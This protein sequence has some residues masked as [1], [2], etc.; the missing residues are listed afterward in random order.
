MSTL[1]EQLRDAVAAA[2]LAASRAGDLNVDAATLPAVRIEHPARP[3]HGDFATNAAMQLAP[4][5][6]SAPLRIAETL[7]RHLELPDAIA[8]AEIAAP[9]FIN[10]RLDPGWVASQA[11]EI[12]TA[13]TAYGHIRV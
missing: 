6:R 4:V 7:V 1:R 2:R 13:G 9:G 10:F 11:E 5:A 8:R 12:R 3:E